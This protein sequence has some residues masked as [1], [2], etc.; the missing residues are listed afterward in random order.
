MGANSS[1]VA[2]A[3]SLLTVKAAALGAGPTAQGVG[4]IV[5]GDLM[6]ARFR[7]TAGRA[8]RALIGLIFLGAPAV[9]AQIAEICPVPEAALEERLATVLEHSKETL[10]IGDDARRTL[11]QALRREA[12]IA[13]QRLDLLK[14]P[15]DRAR[16]R[17][18]LHS[19]FCESGMTGPLPKGFTRARF[20]SLVDLALAV[21]DVHTLAAE[22]G[23]I[24][25]CTVDWHRRV[26]VCMAESDLLELLRE[27][28]VGPAHRRSMPLVDPWGT[29]YKIL[30]TDRADSVKIVSAGEDRRFQ[31]SSLTFYEKP[32]GPEILPVIRGD[33][34]DDLV[35]I[36]GSNFTQLPLLAG[37]EE[38]WIFTDLL[39][40]LDEIDR[41]QGRSSERP[42]SQ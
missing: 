34:A 12:D 23:A 42:S 27:R 16:A 35:F 7:F 14:N 29:P 2:D 21:S 26:F 25:P 28:R 22:I 37:M 9:P 18:Y 39:R 10:G 24:H 13:K 33:F 40:F 5:W 38:T 20:E 17:G 36:S 15:D 6:L 8:Q 4:A 31:T 30:L 3:D 32:G 11:E 1:I 19:V 41:N